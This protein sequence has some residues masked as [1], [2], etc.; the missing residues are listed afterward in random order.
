MS[1]KLFQRT[2]VG[3]DTVGFMWVY[4]DATK[5]PMC[6]QWSIMVDLDN[7]DVIMN[8]T[9]PC[10]VFFSIADDFGKARDLRILQKLRDDYVF[11]GN[12]YD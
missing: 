8:G 10:I 7:Y 12:S 1:E 3:D 9:V 4:T 2:E 6:S 5:V 11:Y